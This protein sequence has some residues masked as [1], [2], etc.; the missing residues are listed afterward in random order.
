MLSQY[1]L[2]LGPIA[3][4]TKTSYFELLAWHGSV[5]MISVTIRVTV[6]VIT[7]RMPVAMV[8]VAVRPVTVGAH[9]LRAD[10]RPSVCVAM[11]CR[12]TMP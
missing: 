2:R 9:A 4:I 5:V 3:R 11:P 8:N 12:I 6:T 7:N 1:L 10:S